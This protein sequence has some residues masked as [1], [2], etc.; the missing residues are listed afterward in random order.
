M[1]IARI[2]QPSISG[3]KRR[4]MP[5]PVGHPIAGAPVIVR[6]ALEPWTTPC[7]DPGRCPI[8]PVYNASTTTLT[9]TVDGTVTITPLDLPNQPEVTHLT[10][11][12]GTQG[13]LS[14][15][16]QKHPD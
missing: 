3:T 13:F 14:L 15:T 11:T 7:P 1:A 4:S 6:Q 2:S 5:I 16:L 12:T 10:A 8:S 9:S